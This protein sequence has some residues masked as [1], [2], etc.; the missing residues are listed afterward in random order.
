MPAM[1]EELGEALVTRGHPLWWH[2]EGCGLLA[3]NV[4]RAIL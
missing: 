4:F 3:A 2:A 1:Q